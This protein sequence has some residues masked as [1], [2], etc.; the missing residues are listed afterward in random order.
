MAYNNEAMF[1][2]NG[3]SNFTSQ[4]SQNSNPIHEEFMSLLIILFFC[5]GFVGY[6]FLVTSKRIKKE[7]N[8]SK[9]LAEKYKTIWNLSI[10][11]CFRC[12]S[13]LLIIIIENKTGSDLITFINCLCHIIPSLVFISIFFSYIQFLIEKYYEI[14]SKKTNIFFAPSIN[15]FSFL[16]YVAFF[17][18]T[19]SCLTTRHYRTF[20]YVSNGIICLLSFV[21]GILYLYYGIKI[22]SFYS[23]V[24]LD[25]KEK[26]YIYQRVLFISIIVGGTYF[27]R[28]LISFFISIG[29][30]G[31]EYPSF[32]NVNVWDFLVF[33]MTELI[34]SLVIGF[35]KKHKKKNTLV[36]E[37]EKYEFNEACTYKGSGNFNIGVDKENTLNHNNSLNNNNKDM[38]FFDLE[39]PL[40][41]KFENEK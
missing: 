35:S 16:I 18:I 39:D 9:A 40:L 8:E 27:I 19:I 12:I 28:G 5:F 30:F 24:D 3:T 32:L 33:L 13:L 41:E 20:L 21:L 17:V 7:A 6:F 22:S 23:K 2:I 10:A 4:P 38:H 37:I 11:N 34:C 26:N 15:F 14:K 1:S 36:N 25:S 29:W 31:K